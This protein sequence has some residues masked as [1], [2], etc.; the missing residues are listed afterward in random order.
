M[1]GLYSAWLVEVVLITYRATRPGSNQGTRSLPWPLPAEYAATFV[2][3]GALGLVSGRGQ[4]VASL[5]G[6]GF[7]VATLLNFWDPKTGK[8]KSATAKTKP[9]GAPD[10][11]GTLTSAGA[12]QTG[13]AA[14]NFAAPGQN[15]N[16]PP[17]TGGNTR[18][19]G[20]T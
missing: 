20:A 13:T 11:G 18:T 10:Y 12:G 8:V 1:A 19:A 17:Y 9:T 6:W 16:A 7:V 5:V 14:T 15:P 3:F 2:I 4:R